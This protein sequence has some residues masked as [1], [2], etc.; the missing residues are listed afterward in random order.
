M[1]TGLQVRKEQLNTIQKF[2][3]KAMPQL[4]AALP[5][6]GLTPESLARAAFTTIVDSPHLHGADPRTLVKCIIEAAQLGF[7]LDKNLGHA[8]LV[9]FK[10]KVQL[11]P[12][13]RGYVALADRSGLVRDVVMQ[14]VFD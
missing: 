12:G 3:D 9:P 11:M 7:S 2:L 5:R 1:N 14:A 10:G 13:Y 8:Y 4:Q 6:I